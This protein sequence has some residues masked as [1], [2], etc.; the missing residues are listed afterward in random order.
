M[1]DFPGSQ[2]AAFPASKTD[3]DEASAGLRRKTLIG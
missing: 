3:I 2:S 1:I